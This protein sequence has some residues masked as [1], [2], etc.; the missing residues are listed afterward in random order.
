MYKKISTW[1]ILLYHLIKKFRF[2]R[3]DDKVTLTAHKMSIRMH[4]DIDSI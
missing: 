2:D 1:S 4:V 3:V